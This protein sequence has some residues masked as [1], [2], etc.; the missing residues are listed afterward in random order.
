MS[1]PPV[2][3]QGSPA[4]AAAAVPATTAVTERRHFSPTFWMLNIIEMW[5]RLAYYV[6]RPVAPIYIMQA[7]EPGGLHL[8]LHGPYQPLAAGEKTVITLKLADGRALP[9]QF[10]VRKSAP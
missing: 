5:E 10:E 6:L 4:A 3:T 1:N 2:N 8:M 9:V 7:T